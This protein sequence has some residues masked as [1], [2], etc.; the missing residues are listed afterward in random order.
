MRVDTLDESAER[1]IASK[2]AV[3]GQ[4][5]MVD[6]HKYHR[7]TGKPGTITQCIHVL[8]EHDAPQNLLDPKDVPTGATALKLWPDRSPAS[9]VIS[10]TP[11]QI[12]DVD[13]NWLKISP[14]VVGVDPE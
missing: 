12:V 1:T 13:E 7:L 5:V 4:H 10:G 14:M 8:R 2:S 11:F 3:A 9:D 6:A